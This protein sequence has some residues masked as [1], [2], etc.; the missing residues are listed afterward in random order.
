MSLDLAKC[1]FWSAVGPG[2]VCGA[3]GDGQGWGE[4][5]ARLGEG[6]YLI[7]KEKRKNGKQNPTY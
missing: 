1:I 5:G 3:E 4:G 6:G 7:G 2:A